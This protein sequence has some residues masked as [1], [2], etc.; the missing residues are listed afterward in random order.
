ML[1]LSLGYNVG[2]PHCATLTPHPSS[3]NNPSTAMTCKTCVPAL[4]IALQAEIAFCS[5]NS[6]QSG[7]WVDVLQVQRCACPSTLQVQASRTQGFWG[8]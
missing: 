4:T 6:A 8:C 5:A 3:A 7:R 2:G 1:A